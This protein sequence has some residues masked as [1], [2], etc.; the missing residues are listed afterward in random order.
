MEEE[1]LKNCNAAINAK[2]DKED[3]VDE[4]RNKVDDLRGEPS[5]N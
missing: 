2:A 3:N 5:D 1:F 4:E